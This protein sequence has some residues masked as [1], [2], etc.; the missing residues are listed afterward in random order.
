M[1]G[2]RNSIAVTCTLFDWNVLEWIWIRP[3][4][5]ADRYVS[6][7]PRSKETNVSTKSD[8]L[9]PKT[10]NIHSQTYKP[11][12]HVLVN[13]AGADHPETPPGRAGTNPITRRKG[14]QPPIGSESTYNSVRRRRKTSTRRRSP[15]PC[16]VV[17]KKIL[18]SLRTFNKNSCDLFTA[19]MY[20]KIPVAYL[21]ISYKNWCV[22]SALR[23][24][25]TYYFV[26]II[27]LTK[28]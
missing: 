10:L 26:G 20:I 25:T 7:A 24:Q 16:V 13:R 18:K 28:S 3:L 14:P 4:L 12:A 21:I 22:S 2:T 23:H 27:Y 11:T 19:I 15:I 9:V 17:E 6:D 5:D 8:A 1:G